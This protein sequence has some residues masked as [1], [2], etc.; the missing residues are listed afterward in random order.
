[1]NGRIFNKKPAF[2]VRVDRELLGAVIEPC[3]VG[4]VFA[5]F[6]SC[7]PGFSPL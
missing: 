6:F 4:K 2:E 7:L 5:F 1:L 3:F